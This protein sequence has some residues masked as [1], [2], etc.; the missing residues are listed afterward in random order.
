MGGFDI[1]FDAKQSENDVPHVGLG[2]I[3]LNIKQFEHHVLDEIIHL[4]NDM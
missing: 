3:V 2:V 1:N 4:E